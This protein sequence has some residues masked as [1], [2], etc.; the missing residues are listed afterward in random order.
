MQKLII[1]LVTT[2]GLSACSI[3][4]P[5]V[6]NQT[7][8]LQD[9]DN[10]GVINAR[11]LCKKTPLNAIINNDGCHNNFN[12]LNQYKLRVLFANNST[13]ITKDTLDQISIMADN[14][15][16]Y[17]NTNLQLQGFASKTGSSAYNKTLSR[18]RALAVRSV[19][20][21][22]Y[23]ISANRLTIIGYGDTKPA[24]LGDTEDAYAQNRRVTATLV[25]KES[26]VKQRWTI[27]SSRAE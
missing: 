11:D 4:N 22:D 8:D 26:G 3:Q 14:L 15:S 12:K 20:I 7:L 2:I 1:I 19:L 23:G 5:P 13:E 27:Y 21:N 17:P 16:K 18:K 10:D 6:A 9:S 24:A 25:N